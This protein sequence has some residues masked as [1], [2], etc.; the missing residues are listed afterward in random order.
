MSPKRIRPFLFPALLLVLLIC[1]CVLYAEFLFQRPS[2]QRFLVEKISKAVAYDV[3][4]KSF[5]I[6]FWKGLN[7][8]AHGLSVE[9]R[10]HKQHIDAPTARIGLT[11]TALFKGNVIPSSLDLSNP[12]ISISLPGRQKTKKP[13]L[14]ETLQ[15]TTLLRLVGIR[16]L[17]I[18]GGQIK[19]EG[20]PFSLRALFLRMSR[21]KEKPEE[22][23]IR[24]KTALGFKGRHI[25]FQ[26][27]GHVRYPEK[28]SQIAVDLSG[29]AGRIPVSWIP[30]PRF[31]PF[32][33]GIID[34]AFQVKGALSGTLSAEGTFTGHDLRF[35]ISGRERRKEYAFS[36]M[37]LDF[38]AQLDK[39]KL[40][41]NIP[42]AR[43]LDTSL[44]ARVFYASKKPSP[45]LELSIKS[46]FMSLKTFKQIFPSSLVPAWIEKSLFPR[47]SGG[48]VMAEHFSLGGTL[49]QIAHLNRPENMNALAMHVTWRNLHVLEQGPAL[50]FEEVS[51]Q[52]DI[53][54][55]RLK[56]A[57]M[58]GRF[59]TSSVHQGLFAV[60]P[61]AGRDRLYSTAVEGDFS[62]EDLL[63]MR[64]LPWIPEDLSKK[65]ASL[66][67]SSG[68]LEARVTA[69]RKGSG[70]IPR[71]K[72]GSL[73]FR[74]CTFAHRALLF[75]IFITRGE[76]EMQDTGRVQFKG[77]GSW[78][79]SDLK[80]SGFTDRS[81]EHV[82]TKVDGTL[83]LDAL[84]AKLFPEKPWSLHFE[85][86]ADC[87]LHITK[88]D[89][90]WSLAGTIDLNEKPALK[91]T[92]LHLNPLCNKGGICF[93]LAYRPGKSLRIKS[94][95]AN[96]G[97]SLFS[98]AGDVALVGEK[99]ITAEINIPG[100]FFKDLGVQFQGN[101][102]VAAGV[103]KGHIRGTF[104]VRDLLSST[105]TGELEARD[106]CV[107]PKRLSHPLKGGFRAHFSGD[108]VALK[109]LHFTTGKSS[110]EIE[111]NL[112]GWKG[113]KGN[114]AIRSERI[115]LAD[116]LAEKKPRSQKRGWFFLRPL[117]AHSDGLSVSFQASKV[118]WHA[119]KT[120]PLTGNGVLE[121]GMFHL[122]ES[123]LKS[124][125][126][127]IT[128]KGHLPGAPG[129]K[130]TFLSHIR[131][132]EQ[133]VQELFQSFNVQNHY[134]EGQLSTDILVSGQ[135]H[136][137]DSLT[138]GLQGNGKMLLE[139]GVIKK[140]NVLIKILDFLS[141]Q[142]IFRRPPP[143]L[144]KEGFYFDRIGADFIIRK[145]VLSTEN[146]LMRSPVINAA[147][148]AR[149]NLPGKKVR[150]DLGVQPLV[151]LDSLVSKIPIVGY[152]LTGKDKTLL[153]YYFKVE[154][155]ISSPEVKYIPLKKWGNSIMGYVTRI[156]LTP[157]RLFEKLMNL[158]KPAKDESSLSGPPHQ[159]D[160]SGNP[161]K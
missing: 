72:N 90:A 46:P 121:K 119:M 82:T 161:A 107:A 110:I 123:S 20:S 93:D 19:I 16:S 81:L 118:A 149:L 103:L 158:R 136:N 131:L 29:R 96:F 25:P 63:E 154:G 148:K 134:I 9:S 112:K 15:N 75:P 39:G 89:A 138:A 77:D 14:E 97:K 54:N 113:L 79:D 5:H 48:E 31:A 156:F 6:Y 67:G 38:T 104:P 151:T 26:L 86:P 42:R 120:G 45:H 36:S 21:N 116:F 95:D 100:I 1:A 155:P 114:L 140:S 57:R 40:T 141:I 101:C 71:V 22:Q 24:L 60:T 64:R 147:G 2:V 144:S 160:M 69:F 98:A 32:S 88:K 157:P 83:D 135:G 80:V 17:T 105:L 13:S 65:L 78:G 23:F 50:P 28:K 12:I 92:G 146:L 127:L 51:G 56:L 126:G 85:K 3:K 33:G 30:W 74:D 73:T 7:I 133:P 44:T 91:G 142:K 37:D 11:W 8:A 70:L 137:L 76:I 58:Q 99:R 10:D 47:L 152:I 84:A 52:M 125:H 55:N 117:L 4:V 35:A 94:L 59:G 115:D 41:V 53:S 109:S 34:A 128:L 43:V 61:L 130:I 132:F 139:K 111:G 122:T 87:S 159:E 108:T 129:K 145:G 153:V 150:A 27:K 18:S 49:D 124:E 106:L 62:V 66:K 102:P 68:R 143:N